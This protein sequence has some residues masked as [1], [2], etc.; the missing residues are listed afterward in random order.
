[1]RTPIL[2]ALVSVAGASLV[3]AQDLPDAEPGQCYAKVLVPAEFE[4]RSERVLMQP[5]AS[6][7]RV[8]PAEYETVTEEVVVKEESVEYTVIP[9]EYEYREKRVMI[10][11]EKK[12]STVIP[13]VFKDVDQRV[14]VTPAHY[15][16]KPG[17]GPFQR[18]DRA[19]GEILCR[20]EVPPVYKLVK[21]R[22]VARPAR[23]E[24]RVTPAEYKTIR[25]RVVVRPAELKKRVIPAETRM[26][27]VERMLETEVTI[28]ETTE[29]VYRDVD[30][31]VKVSSERFEYRP[32]LCETNATPDVI[33]RVQIALKNAGFY[34][35][36]IDGRIGRGTR[37]AVN[38]F[39][40]ENNLESGDL[41]LR[42]LEVLGVD[43]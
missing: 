21:K 24:T 20:V 38:A 6:T 3:Q 9:A 25:T 2:V 19:T 7:L 22:I 32:I 12:Y 30:T 18:I 35:G 13:P 5:E 14:L 34:K 43:L 17:R 15:V 41:T 36:T 16:W 4:T 42:T 27:E 1:M 29:P 26:I 8:R 10:S 33:R 28:P 23:I 40:R 37:D 11:P 39:Q 31:N